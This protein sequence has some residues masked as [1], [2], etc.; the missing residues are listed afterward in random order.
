MAAAIHP[1]DPVTM[2]VSARQFEHARAVLP[3]GVRVVEMSTDDSWMRD[4]GPTFVVDGAGARRAVDWEFNAWGGLEGG[5]YFPWD[6]DDL[7]A[8]KVA[9]I[10]ADGPPP[11]AAGARGRLHPRRRRGHAADD[12]G[13]PAEPQPQPAAH[14]R[15]D[16]GAAPGLPRHRARGLP[17]RKSASKSGAPCEDKAGLV[18]SS[19]STRQVTWPA[20]DQARQAINQ[21]LQ[22]VAATGDQRVE[23]FSQLVH[24]AG[25]QYEQHKQKCQ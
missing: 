24:A 19:F 2:A 21:K 8:A 13:V 20:A 23:G 12:R 9:E 10:E 3:P 7:V 25:A 11:R 1:S 14:A 6:Q 4:S 22:A 15:G 16:R 5:L 17:S 18:Q